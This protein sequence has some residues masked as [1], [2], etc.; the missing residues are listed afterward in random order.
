MSFVYDHCYSRYVVTQGAHACCHA[1]VG[2][3]PR[4]ASR[5]EGIHVL[6]GKKCLRPSLGP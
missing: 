5:E 2:V 3:P 1:R 6:D 4:N